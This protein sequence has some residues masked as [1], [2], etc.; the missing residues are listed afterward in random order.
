M[1]VPQWW[2][3]FKKNFTGRNFFKI[4]SRILIGFILV[5]AGLMKLFNP[6]IFINVLSGIKEIP[7]DIIPSMA[8]ILPVAEIVVGMFLFVRVLY[9]DYVA[10]AL[11]FSFLLFLVYSYIN[12]NTNDCGCFG[13]IVESKIDLLSI[14]RQITIVGLN[15]FILDSFVEQSKKSTQIV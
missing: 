5:F 10:L 14:F 4:T 13:N 9:S 1:N 15:I 8:I 11:N 12:G 2:L 7:A 3:I 6:I